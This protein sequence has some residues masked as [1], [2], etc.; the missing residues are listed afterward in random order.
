[1]RKTTYFDG[2]KMT[3]DNGTLIVNGIEYSKEYVANQAK[4]ARGISRIRKPAALL[5]WIDCKNNKNLKEW[6]C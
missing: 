6:G 4:L 2:M 5:F 1:M 3:Y